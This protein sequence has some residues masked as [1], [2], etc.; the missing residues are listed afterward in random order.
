MTHVSLFSG[1]GGLDLAA[2]W[3]GFRSILQVEKDEKARAVLAKHWPDVPRIEDIREVTSE[4]VREPVGVISGGF[5]CQPFSHAGKRGGTSDDR[6]LWPEMLRVIQCLKPRWVVAENVSGLL[7]I[8]EGLVFESVLSDLGRIGY[9]TLPLHYPASGVG[10]PH[11]RDRV[12][13]VGHAQCS[14]AGGDIRGESSRARMGVEWD[15]LVHP[16]RDEEKHV[17]D[18]SGQDV[19]DAERIGQSPKGNGKL[20]R[21][22]SDAWQADQSR[23]VGK[24]SV[25][26]ANANGTQCQRGSVPVGARKK[27]ANISNTRWWES[28]PDVGRLANGIPGRVDRLKQLGNAVVPQQAYPIFKAIM[29]YERG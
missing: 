28:E 16:G 18:P 12:F 29:E 22:T 3:A 13:I 1:I 25:A 8:D 4:S 21:T 10:A 11:K 9:E 23:G 27:H 14:D 26:A 19:A 7:S 5:P 2:E 6:F 24:V 15:G 20:D 17:T